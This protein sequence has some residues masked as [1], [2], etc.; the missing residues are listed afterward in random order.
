MHLPR[1]QYDCLG[2]RLL[3]ET[4]VLTKKYAKQ[5]GVFGYMHR[6]LLEISLGAAC[7]VFC[8]SRSCVRHFLLV[9]DPVWEEM[10][11][12]IKCVRNQRGHD[13]AADYGRDKSR[14]LSL[15]DNP[16]R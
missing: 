10:L 14:I 5:H 16:M 13:R 12:K 2:E 7:C 9:L 6:L 4:I 15:V 11:R 1:P 3:L 8:D